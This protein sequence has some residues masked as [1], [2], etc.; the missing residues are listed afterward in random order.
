MRYGKVVIIVN[1]KLDQRDYYR[2]GISYFL[3]KGTEVEILD[4]SKLALSS[5]YEPDAF[6]KDVSIN[7]A[8]NTD[9]LEDYLDKNA[10][11]LFIDT[12][13]LHNPLFKD[14]RKPFAARNIDTLVSLGGDIPGLEHFRWPCDDGYHPRYL[15]I[16]AASS[17]IRAPSLGPDTKII[18]AHTYDYERY[19][20]FKSRGESVVVKNQGV[21]YDQYLPFHPDLHVMKSKSIDP[22]KY[23]GAVC[24]FLSMIEASLGMP[25]V[26]A[27]H[28]RARYDDPEKYYGGRKCFYDQTIALT[29]ESKFVVTHPSTAVS[30]P[31]LL[32][33]PII[34]TTT[35]DN[36]CIPCSQFFGEC[37]ESEL[38]LKVINLDK[39]M[40][41]NLNIAASPHR[42][43]T[44]RQRYIK[45][46]VTKDAPLWE[47]VYDAIAAETLKS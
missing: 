21:F 36:N 9:D 25:I 10:E 38:N 15:V 17:L 29:A 22:D 39:P 44:Y 14:V 26:I 33:K 12:V 45:M 40:P 28:P 41:S 13:D 35:D 30:Y 46:A 37:L 5:L 31:V 27:L 2:F 43:Y 1:M 34:L 23:Y 24:R 42:Y 20:E 11:C 18:L 4:I 7:L 3:N 32:N 8:E 19:L 6:F 16:G 47:I